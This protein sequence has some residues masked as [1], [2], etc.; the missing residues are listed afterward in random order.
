MDDHRQVNRRQFL[1]G[2]AAV[3]VA[4]AGCASKST[5]AGSR[6]VVAPGDELAWT[7]AT[8]L[9]KLIRDKKLSP[10][11]LTKAVLERA[12]SLNPKLH[13]F[14]F[15]DHEGAMAAAKGAEDAVMKGDSLGLLHGVPV[16]IKDGN[17]VK[18]MPT[19]NG[20]KITGTT[21][22]AEDGSLTASTRAAGA[23]IFGKTNLPA[24]AHK[25]V[26]ENLLIP[27]CPTP[28]KAGY[29]SGGSSG[30]AGAAAAA[31]I[32]P[33]HHGSDGGGSI[34][35][36]ADRCGVFGF[37]P[38]IGR[39]GHPGSMKAAAVG[40]DGPL[41]RAVADSALLM[42]VWSGPNRLDYLSIDSPA[43][44]FSA[45]VADWEKSLKGRK[46][47]LVFDYGW[48]PAVDP[49]VRRL[50]TAAAK[51]FT[52][53]GVTVEETTLKWPSPMMAW[54]AVWYATAAAARP[55]FAGHEDW[56][57]PTLKEQMDAGARISGPE[58]ADALEMK[59]T[60]FTAVQ[61]FF[62]GYD[63]LLSPVCA[64]PTFPFDNP[65]TEAGGVPFAT[66]DVRRLIWN[67]RIPFTP[68]FNMSGHPAASAPAGFTK[69]GLPVG[70]HI[71]AAR[72]QDALV[73][74]AAAG[75]EAV[76]PWAS[77]KPPV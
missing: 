19:T 40:H 30:G 62:D 54:E 25:D 53:L 4:V 14:L 60:I 58:V 44:N 37:K 41:T 39:I 10:V 33:L 75:L 64:V 72:H 11:E 61:K 3:G 7:P 27:A 73:L 24:F 71:V 69:E 1:I 23:V 51:K 36:P 49:E 32:G 46:A 55:R 63:L 26:T 31:G 35:I 59:D 77:A 2:V 56:I 28:W 22:A 29:N 52:D 8:E 38:S 50:V 17:P 65:P 34:R 66:G 67:A 57:D 45:A 16:S 9:A 48:I 43:P 47:A 6:A 13:A 21:P 42:D 20:S 68:A 18:G 74:Q 5:S 76:Q 70:L 12:D 15:I